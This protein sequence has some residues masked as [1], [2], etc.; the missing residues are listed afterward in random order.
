VKTIDKELY[1]K[2]L[3]NDKELARY[4]AFDPVTLSKSKVNMSY[5]QIEYEVTGDP[6]PYNELTK[7]C[8]IDIYCVYPFEL[9][10]DRLLV[11]Q[12]SISREKIK[13]LSDNGRITSSVEKN[14]T[15]LKLNDRLQ[16]T[17]YPETNQYDDRIEELSS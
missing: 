12:L 5:E 7:A 1:H 16:I 4:Y 3:S 13:K 6:L 8:Q 11:R 2:F 17:L 15:K 10:L 9:R 14:L